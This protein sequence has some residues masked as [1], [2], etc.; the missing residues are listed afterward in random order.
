MRATHVGRSRSIDRGFSWKVGKL[1]YRSRLGFVVFFFTL[2]CGGPSESTQSDPRESATSEPF[3]NVSETVQLAASNQ[4]WVL[5]PPVSAGPK[6][7][8]SS[9]APDMKSG[10]RS[11]LNWALLEYRSAF[12][13]RDLKKLES[14]WS[15]GAVER[16]LI[17][18]AW[19]SCEKIELSLETLAMRVSGPSAVVDFDQELT[20]LCPNESRT[21]HSSLSASL[22]RDDAGQWS[23]VRIG[24]RQKDPVRTA[25]AGPAHL[26]PRRERLANDVATTRALETLSDYESALQR[27]DLDG[28]A[29]V[30]IMTELERQILEGLCFR[31]GQ[32]ELR[33]TDPQVS[34][35]DGEIS[36]DFIHDLTRQ[37]RAGPMQTRSKLTALLIERDDGNWAIWKVRAAE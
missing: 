14:I 25:R 23:I 8:K 20:F 35:D 16:L 12:V 18:S 37:S 31:R 6:S 5:L 26:A 21:S 15:M 28:L 2:A 10:L 4:R 11:R 27:C 9:S 19:S 13:G 1:L 36:I 30:W 22:K 33:I 17:K 24:D 34:T 32:L 7:S 3:A 29:R